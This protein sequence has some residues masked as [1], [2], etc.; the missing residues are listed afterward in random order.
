[1]FV[2]WRR[3]CRIVFGR[4]YGSKLSN[5]KHL[6]DQNE[7][8]VRRLG[9]ELVAQIEGEIQEHASRA[10]AVEAK[11]LEK[12]PTGRYRYAFR[13][14]PEGNRV[15]YRQGTETNVE[16]EV[17]DLSFRDYELHSMSLSVD[18]MLLACIVSPIEGS[19]QTPQLWIRN[20]QTHHTRCFV[21]DGEEYCGVEFGPAHAGDHTIFYTTAN[22]LHRPCAVYV[23]RV[24]KDLQMTRN[25]DQVYRSDDEAVFVDVQRTKGCQ[26]I[27]I[28]GATKTSSETLLSNGIGDPL[29]VKPRTHDIQYG[30][31]VG[32]RNDV[33]VLASSQ[34]DGEG[35][36]QEL[37]F[38][39]RRVSD[40]PLSSL[41]QI[42]ESAMSHFIEDIDLFQSHVVFYERSTSDGS[43]RVRVEN[44]ANGTDVV[45]DSLD[46][47][48]CTSISP[49]GN[50]QLGS[51]SVCFR[52]DRPAQTP[53]VYEF[54]F[55]SGGLTLLSGNDQIDDDY[56]EDIVSVESWDGVEIPM[57]VLYKANNDLGR[58]KI[59]ILLYGYGAYGQPVCQGFDPSV[60]PL[61]D[62][63]V[64]VAY[65]HT[66][67]GGEL[68]RAWYEAG[69][70]Q[71]KPNAIEDY[72]ACARYLGEQSDFLDPSLTA[73]AVSAGGVVVG[74][75]LNRNPDL[76]SGAIFVNAYL[77]LGSMRRTDLPLTEHE[78]EEW[79]NPTVDKDASDL[80]SSICPVSNIE[81][82]EYPPMLL[83]GALDDRNVPFQN[84]LMYA[85]E[86]NKCSQHK[87]WLY[88]VFQGGHSLG[89]S[90]LEVS[91][92]E[93]AF[94]LNL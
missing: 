67:G 15:Y 77:D 73:K 33:V 3:P 8:I 93:A 45:L 24:N 4:R 37:T 51:A 82:K 50:M 18:E 22:S 94:L 23:C 63:G 19:A 56:R 10:A 5:T 30:V 70:S 34:S 84:S 92:L 46:T 85:H 57:T 71:N 61:L 29:L 64:V 16:E 59:P 54:E 65:A 81:P 78:W 35:L 49:G 14:G 11:I 43:S 27:A 68:G 74:A 21:A 60:L 9:P 6:K 13:D 69:R 58:T 80:I 38:F 48:P 40:L 52:L 47:S 41:E 1:M 20:L 2:R 36:G 7:E 75:A 66:R 28:T 12:G 90:K 32:I 87:A 76:F 39:E 53:L 86:L 89:G 83:V 55:S 31:D 44:R 17:L 88:T 62:R 72:L 25:P 79:G 26:Y 42:R 91:A